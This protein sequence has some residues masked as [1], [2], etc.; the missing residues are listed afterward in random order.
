M[1]APT[2]IRPAPD[3]AGVVTLML[4]SGLPPAAGCR[5]RRSTAIASS[6]AATP[7]SSADCSARMQQVASGTACGVSARHRPSRDS[8]RAMRPSARAL[9][10]VAH[11][12][13]QDRAI[14]A[15]VPASISLPMSSGAGWGARRRA[16]APSRLAPRGRQ[17]VQCRQHRIGAL[18]AADAVMH[19]LALAA[20]RPA[21]PVRI[22]IA[23]KPP[24]ALDPRMRG[25][26][27]SVCS[28]IGFPSGG[29]YC[30]GTSPPKRR[31]LPAAGT[32][33]R[34]RTGGPPVQRRG[35]GRRLDHR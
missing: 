11:R 20:R 21:R 4:S 25:R 13:G 23:S 19:G 18:A 27:S 9:Q 26:A 28:S 31:P 8:V 22:V 5:P 17:C 30:L 3:R 14:G 15:R 2:G 29:R 33:P 12:C 16:P 35:T 32:T 6:V 24:S 1:R 34:S 7:S 10:G